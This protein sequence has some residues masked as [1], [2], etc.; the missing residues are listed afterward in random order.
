MTPTYNERLP[1][2]L[3]T[4]DGYQGPLLTMDGYHSIYLQWMVIITCTYN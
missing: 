2:H 1:L 4:M 3:F